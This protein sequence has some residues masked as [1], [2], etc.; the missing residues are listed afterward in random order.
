MLEVKQEMFALNTTLTNP[1]NREL[2]G[3]LFAWE[4]RYRDENQFD[5]YTSPCEEH[6]IGPNGTQNII[7]KQL[8]LIYYETIK[9]SPYHLQQTLT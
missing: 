8:Y 1:D 7:L 3:C 9:D 2:S 4:G 5:V 6:I